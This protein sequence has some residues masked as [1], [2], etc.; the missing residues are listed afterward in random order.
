MTAGDQDEAKLPAGQ[1]SNSRWVPPQKRLEGVVTNCF[2][3]RAAFSGV[4][5]E[6]WATVSRVECCIAFFSDNA[7]KSWASR[8]TWMEAH[9]HDFKAL[10]QVCYDG[11]NC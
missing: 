3:K 2:E 9:G 1:A 8:Q 4:A 10:P 5:S 7:H 11:L 6:F